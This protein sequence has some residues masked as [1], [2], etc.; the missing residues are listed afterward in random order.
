MI[1]PATRSALVPRRPRLEIAGVPLHITQRGVN[2]AAVFVDDA[3]RQHFLDLLGK[4]LARFDIALHAYVLMGNHVHLLASA[5][6]TGLISR[7]MRNLGQ[8]YVQAFNRRH[9]RTGTLWESRFKSCLVASDRYLLTVYR[10]IEL[11]PM[12]AALAVHPAAYRWS[13]VHANL[14]LRDDPLVTPHPVFAALGARPATRAARYRAWLHEAISA[15]ECDAIRAHLEQERAWG[16]K[17]FQAM[18]EKTL[19]RPAAVRP[20]GRP[21]RRPCTEPE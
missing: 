6:E 9:G 21:V 7:A 1:A 2:R 15:E 4:G 12:R 11:N 8:C 3:D 16:D 20:R 19:N 13:S 14:A 5:P 10:Y 17:R 18:V